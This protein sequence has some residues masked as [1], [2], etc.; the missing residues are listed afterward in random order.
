M[1]TIET[2]AEGK[3]LGLYSRDDW[4]FAD[5]PNATGVVGILP[6]TDDG[7]LVLIEQY[8]FPVQSR[9]IEIPAGL[10]GDEEEFKGESLAD[11]A[12]RELLEE[13][14]YRAG[15]V[16]PLLSGPTSPGMTPEITHLF[17]ATELTRETEGGGTE[18]EDITVHHV[19]LDQ[20]SDWLIQQQVDGRLLD[21]K[22]HASL[23]LA[24]TQ[25]LLPPS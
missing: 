20:L 23:W 13:T 25:G 9:V 8:R 7:Q 22:I 6:I 17:A 12:A 11:C 19:P 16:T 15:V 18:S 4:E 5:R 2:L 3:Y 1:S 14:G 10:V 24:Q 21:N